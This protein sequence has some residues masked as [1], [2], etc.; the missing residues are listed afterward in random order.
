MLSKFTKKWEKHA[1]CTTDKLSSIG[2]I[3]SWREAVQFYSQNDQNLQPAP[4]DEQI[5]LVVSNWIEDCFSLLFQLCSTNTKITKN[6]QVYE[7]RAH[8]EETY[9][10][11]YVLPIFFPR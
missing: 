6:N 10:Q 2:F 1:D 11:A 8:K 4:G 5:K 3:I 9:H 7:F